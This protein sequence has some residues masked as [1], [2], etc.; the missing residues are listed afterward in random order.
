MILEIHAKN[1]ALVRTA[2]INAA[3]LPRVGEVVHSPADAEYLQGISTLLVVDVRHELGAA[4]M[5]A[6][7]RCIARGQPEAMRL[8]ELQEA[9]WLPA[10]G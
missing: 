1:G 2:V 6:I 4:G 7:V 5:D 9:G 8:A 10:V 3:H